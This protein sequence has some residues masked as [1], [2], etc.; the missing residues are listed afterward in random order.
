MGGEAI[1]RRLKLTSPGR[2]ETEANVRRLNPSATGPHGN[3]YE[4]YC[5]I[6]SFDAGYPLNISARTGFDPS[7]S[8]W[9]NLGEVR[10]PS[11]TGPHDNLYEIQPMNL[12]CGLACGHFGAFGTRSRVNLVVGFG[13]GP[14][15]EA[16]M[17]RLNPLATGPEENLQKTLLIYTF[18]A[19]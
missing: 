7:S 19:G 18:A 15:F 5:I 6:C 12:C 16:S 14:T 2:S 13:G 10:K 1:V 4:I 17:R 8:T 9:W 3:L 11:T